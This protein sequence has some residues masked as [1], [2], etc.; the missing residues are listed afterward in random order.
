MIG[1][2]LGSML[3]TAMTDSAVIW[4]DDFD[5]EYLN[6]WTIV[7]LAPGQQSDW[8]VY[9]GFLVH[10]SNIGGKKQL[11]SHIVAGDREWRNYTVRAELVF[12]DD[13]YIGI[14]FRYRDQKNYYRFFLSGQNGQSFLEK[15]VKGDIQRLG[16]FEE[17]LD[18]CKMTMTAAVHQDTIRVYLNDREYFTVIDS[19]HPTGKVGFMTCYNEGAYFDNIVVSE[20]YEPMIKVVK[21]RL[22]FRCGPYLQNVL[23]DSA[24]IMWQTNLPANSI[25]EYGRRKGSAR[26][27]E[28]AGS[29]KIHEI[30]LRNLRK[31]ARYFYR[32]I[33]DSLQSEWFS[34]RSYN[35]NRKKLRFALYGDS[36]N[37]FMVH[38]KIAVAIEKHDP[39]FI[40]HAGDLAHGGRTG[41]QNFFIRR[42]DC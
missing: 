17:S 7:D 6:G 27:I 24:T 41:Q 21:P 12:T 1:P 35:P 26:R 3:L 31:N 30:C 4:Q 32:V 22:D 18:E 28:V 15:R 14:L 20:F 29:R 38:R 23:G 13:D 9:D 2:I 8:H 5:S 39:E 34:F 42:A 19:S 11:G 37:N 33:S 16:F 36:Q 25:V 10:T 40:V